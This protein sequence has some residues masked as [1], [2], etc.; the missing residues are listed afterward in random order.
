MK[1]KRKKKPASRRKEGDDLL[2]E[3]NSG[4]TMTEVELL[5]L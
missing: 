3:I 1:K 4:Y 5:V 2:T